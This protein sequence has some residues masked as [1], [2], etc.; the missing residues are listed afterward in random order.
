MQCSI[1][2]RTIA[3]LA[4]AMRKPKLEVALMS[5]RHFH[6]HQENSLARVAKATTPTSALTNACILPRR[7][8]N[9]KVRGGAPRRGSSQMRD[10]RFSVPQGLVRRLK[11]R[12]SWAKRKRRSVKSLLQDS[13]QYESSRW[14]KM[15]D[16]VKNPWFEV[17]MERSVD[18]GQAG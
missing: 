14:P 11:P 1:G 2:A 8:G 9:E 5:T 10:R 18:C 15:P 6:A 16:L 3:S 7:P 12:R 4:Y 17:D 13:V